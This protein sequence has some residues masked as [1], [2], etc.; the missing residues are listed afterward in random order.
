MWRGLLRL[1]LIIGVVGG[2][3]LPAY[4][5]PAGFSDVPTTYWD[6]TAIQ[7]VGLTNP[8]MQDYGT[9]VFKPTTGETRGLLASAL[10]KAYAPDEPIDPS[11]TFPDLP[12]SDPL[13]PFANVSV[14][15]GWIARFANGNFGPV[16]P[17]PTWLL[18]KSLLLAD[19]GFAPALAG[20]SNLEEGDGDPYVIDANWP[21]VMLGHWLGFHYNHTDESEDIG[22]STNLARDEV[23][24]SLWI[25]TLLSSW[26]VDNANSTYATITLPALGSTVQYKHD[27]TQE[28]FDQVGFPYLYGGEWNKASPSGYCCGS[29]PQGGFDCSGFAWWVMKKYESSYNAAKYRTYAGWSLIQRS[30]SDMAKSTGTHITFSNLKV[31]DLMFFASNGGGSWSDVDH[32]GVF[33]GLNWMVH[34]TGSTDGPVLEWVA[35]GWYYDNFVYGRRVIGGS[36]AGAPLPRQ[37]L[38]AGDA[39]TPHRVPTRP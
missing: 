1:C 34:S 13:Y 27:L 20:L 25:A 22:E 8:W 39:G 11:I 29:Q 4:A 16:N 19:G 14:K 38:L 26:Q 18:D 35:D 36:A 3:L 5:A 2:T 21:Y 6:Y 7:Y 28:G 31:G 30:S 17:V 24:Y 32:V 33:I 23:A 12:T 15:L 9:S 37:Q 10:V